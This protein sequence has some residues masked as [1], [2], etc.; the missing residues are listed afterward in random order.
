MPALYFWCEKGRHRI[1]TREKFEDHLDVKIYCPQHKEDM[2]LLGYG[3][4]G[5]AMWLKKQAENR[6]R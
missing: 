3:H 1:R 4:E 6:R 2:T 5:R